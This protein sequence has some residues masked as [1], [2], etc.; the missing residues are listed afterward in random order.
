ML[1]L[2]SPS[3]YTSYSPLSLFV[4]RSPDTLLTVQLWG[5]MCESLCLWRWLEHILHLSYQRYASL[6]N[7]EFK[8]VCVFFC[9]CVWEGFLSKP[10]RVA[11]QFGPC[12]CVC[13]SVRVCT[14]LMGMRLRRRRWETQQRESWRTVYALEKIPLY[15]TQK[16]QKVASLF[17]SLSCVASSPALGGQC[18]PNN[19]WQR[20]II[21]A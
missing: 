6:L 4:I 8:C 12:V 11:Q 1:S 14:C 7:W 18:D 5:C 15:H 21:E 9:V 13:V 17:S 16:V 20:R 10:M 19:W 3:C 2:P